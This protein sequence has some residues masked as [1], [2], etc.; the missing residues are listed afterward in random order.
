MTEYILNQQLKNNPFVYRDILTIPRNVNFGL[1]LELDNIDPDKVYKLVRSQISEDWKIKG[2]VTLTDGES[3]EIVSPILQNNKDTWIILKELSEL[4][5][6]IEANYSNCSFQVNFDGNFLPSLENKMDF[7]KFFAMYEDIIYRFSKGEDSEYRDSLDIYAAPIFSD[8][9]HGVLALKR[10]LKHYSLEWVIETF[11]GNKR[12]GVEFKTKNQDLIEFRT[13]N[14]TNNPVLWQ[15]YITT[16]YYMLD[17]AYNDKYDKKEVDKYIRKT[18]KLYLLE[19]YELE[20]KEK[21]LDFCNII[22]P[23]DIDKINFMH[24]YLGDNH[25]KKYVLK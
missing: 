12:F 5:C 6:R 20:K 13:P 4:L 17:A 16:F 18:D 19:N 14:M 23:Y 24:Q 1:E 7:L 11:S 21:A 10:G 2:D 8:L 22:F 9:K 15:N 3:A 25:L